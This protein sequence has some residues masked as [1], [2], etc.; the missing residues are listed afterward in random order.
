[1]DADQKCGNAPVGYSDAEKARV[2]STVQTKEALALQNV[3]HRPIR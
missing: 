2:Q 1:M 3:H